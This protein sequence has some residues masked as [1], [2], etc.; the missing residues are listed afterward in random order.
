[1]SFDAPYPRWIVSRC[2]PNLLA[3][4]VFGIPC[5]C[6]SQ[7]RVISVFFCMSMILHGLSDF[8]GNIA[9]FNIDEGIPR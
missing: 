9:T 6:S 1:M 2:L 8:Y 4:R 7:Q 5:S 3:M